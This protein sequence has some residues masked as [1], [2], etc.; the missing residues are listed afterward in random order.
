MSRFLAITGYL[1]FTSFLLRLGFIAG[2]DYDP[3][4]VGP[5]FLVIATSFM[6]AIYNDS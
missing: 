5:V 4:Y 6:L 3:G 2:W 1:L